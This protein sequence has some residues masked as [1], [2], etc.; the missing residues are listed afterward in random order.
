MRK[1]HSRVLMGA[2]VGSG[3]AVLGCGVAN[4]VDTSGADS[5]LGGNQGIVSV[6]APVTIGGNAV[7]VLG[8]SHTSDATT[9]AASSGSGGDVTTDGND[10]LLGGNQGCLLYTSPNPRD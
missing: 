8:D 2:L 6:D 1:I 4:A 5:L 7:S 10:S 9:T 3:L